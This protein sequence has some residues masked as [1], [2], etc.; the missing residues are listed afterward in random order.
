MR[1]IW[2]RAVISPEDRNSSFNLE[3][4][5][6]SSAELS[7]LWKN[8]SA[9]LLLVA[10][11]H[12]GH[13]ADAMAEDCVQEAFIR[14]ARQ[15][16]VPDVPVAWLMKTVKNAAID[17]LRTEKR[18]TNRESLVASDKPRWF[19]SVAAVDSERN[20]TLEMQQAIA[21]LDSMTRDIL[22]A[23]IWNNLTFRQIADAFDVS[24][25]T[26]H[27]KYESGL[28]QLREFMTANTTSRTPVESATA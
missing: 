21:E 4:R 17:A 23:H 3:F 6:L 7:L 16:P 14:L 11:G 25:A 28:K 20:T 13:V 5:V 27:R 19:E 26:A 15:T 18:R 24:H 2:F 8:H 10:R 22:I 12:C 1:Q 9:A